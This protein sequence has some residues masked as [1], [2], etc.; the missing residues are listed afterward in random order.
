MVSEKSQGYGFRQAQ[1]LD[2]PKTWKLSPLN[3][4]QSRT[5]HMHDRLK[6]SLSTHFDLQRCL[7]CVSSSFVHFHRHICKGVPIRV[8]DVIAMCSPDVILCGWLGSKHQLTKLSPCES[9]ES[10]RTEDTPTNKTKKKMLTR[11]VLLAFDVTRVS[12]R[13]RRS[14]P[15]MQH[16]EHL[17]CVQLWDKINL[18]VKHK[19]FTFP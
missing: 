17:C 13:S 8:S 14:E 6:V 18:K 9:T 2:R 11:L 5:I 3:A 4:Y 1:T 19:T 10:E 7:D 16:W 15:H 12:R